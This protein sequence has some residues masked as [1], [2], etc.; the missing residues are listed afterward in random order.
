MLSGQFSLQLQNSKVLLTSQ[1]LEFWDLKTVG[2][3]DETEN[4]IE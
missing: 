3:F 1:K 4:G 2:N